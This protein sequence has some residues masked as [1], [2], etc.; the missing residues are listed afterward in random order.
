MERATRADVARRAAADFRARDRVLIGAE[1]EWL[2]YR[3]E[4]PTRPVLAAETG[5][6]AA[7]PLA[8]GGT[9]TI[10][11]GGQLELAT[12]PAPNPAALVELVEADTRTLVD[13]FAAAGLLLVPLGLDPIRPALRSLDVP[14]YE[15][16]ERY[17][18]V[19]TPAGVQMMTR[20]ASL[21]LNIDFGP[22]PAATWRRAH[23]L[24]P[25]LS[26]AFANSPSADGI[27]ARPISHRQ[28]IW[29]DTDPSRTA[30][31]GGSIGDWHRYVLDAQ[32]MLRG[33]G[34][35]AVTPSL[36]ALTFAE[37]LA[38]DDPPTHEE[39]DLHFTTLFPPVRPRGY[40]E[41]RMIDA[42]P[43]TGRAAAV[44]CVWT[45]LTD[46]STGGEATSLDDS[47]AERWGE[48]TTRGLADPA[49]SEGAEHM[50]ETVAA[51]VRTAHP[52]L[53]AACDSWREQIRTVPR[54]TGAANLPDKAEP[55]G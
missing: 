30:P 27:D 2:V 29:S 10:E 7:G 53:A 43:S 32:V 35:S 31:V 44:A 37:W 39:L 40:L 25:L 8:A 51:R 18:A 45:L 4:D 38:D 48:A 16:M 22:D 54:A 17:F 50:L 15:A 41:L 49:L 9:V 55:V 28:R 13:R 1:V 11:P 33:A 5:R 21:Q 42:L 3:R 52:E 20:T 19:H 46:P 34:S 36:E 6:I 47:L 24:G 26:A 14:R 23:R 12:R